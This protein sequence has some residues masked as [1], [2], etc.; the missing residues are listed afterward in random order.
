M[1]GRGVAASAAIGTNDMSM[2]TSISQL[3]KPAENGYIYT[4]N[5]SSLY[6]QATVI[7]LAK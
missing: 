4:G 6:G 7:S 1:A 5:G 3:M 2:A